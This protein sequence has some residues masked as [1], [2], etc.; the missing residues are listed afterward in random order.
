[1]DATYSFLKIPDDY[2]NLMIGFHER[3]YLDGKLRNYEILDNFLQENDLVG[4]KLYFSDYYLEVDLRPLCNKYPNML[5]DPYNYQSL[6]N[7][8]FRNLAF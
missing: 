1:M 7:D 8:T 4:K 3:Y 5:M 6:V 2:E